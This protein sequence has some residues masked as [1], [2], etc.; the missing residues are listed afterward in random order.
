MK[1]ITL[2]NHYLYMLKDALRVLPVLLI[3]ELYFILKPSKLNL[4]LYTIVFIFCLSFIIRI[5][6]HSIIIGR[7]YKYGKELYGL[8]ILN[9]SFKY[10]FY[11]GIKEYELLKFNNMIDCNKDFNYIGVPCDYEYFNAVCL[12]YKKYITVYK[13][14]T[15]LFYLQRQIEFS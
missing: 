8:V 4:I 6:F 3:S 11:D 1:Q 15:T 7:I 9:E 10:E 13:Y 12:K 2:N 14:D 5:I